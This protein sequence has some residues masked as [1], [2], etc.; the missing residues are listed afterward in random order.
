[1]YALEISL[2]CDFLLSLSGKQEPFII[3]SPLHKERWGQTSQAVASTLDIVPTVL[4]WFGIKDNTSSYSYMD[5]Q[6]SRVQV[7]VGCNII[8]NIQLFFEK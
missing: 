8:K 1:M 2:N 4:D 5:D 7:S 3:S 6:G